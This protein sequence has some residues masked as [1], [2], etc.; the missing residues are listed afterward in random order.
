MKYFWIAIILASFGV[1]ALGV[2]SEIRDSKRKIER[3]NDLEQVYQIGYGH[4]VQA[5]I[6]GCW[7]RT[8]KE[9]YD[10]NEI[11]WRAARF[12]NDWNGMLRKD[13]NGTDFYR[14]VPN[15]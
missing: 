9:V 12:H 3:M 4:G 8:N 14:H 7:T 2:K 1:I 6:F 13:T 11:E 10:C 5:G 15:P